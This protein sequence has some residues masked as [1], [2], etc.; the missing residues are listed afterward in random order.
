M[1]KIAFILLTVIIAS[2]TQSTDNTTV[3]EIEDL[4]V[5]EPF[6]R[7]PTYNLKWLKWQSEGTSF[8]EI[9]EKCPFCV[10][11]L[12]IPKD[13]ILKVSSE[14]DPKR[15]ALLIKVLDVFD[16]L[17]AYFPPE[18]QDKVRT[19]CSNPSNISKEQIEFLKRL[20]DEAIT[21]NDKLIALKNIS[22]FSLRETKAV[23]DY[24]KSKQI[25]MSYF[26]NFDSV[27]TQAKVARLNNSLED[28]IRTAG[29]LQGEVNLQKREISKT[30][31]QHSKD[32]NNFLFTAGYQY[33]VSINPVGNDSYQLVLKYSGENESI[34]NV[35]EHLSFGERNAFAL[36][37]FMYQT[38]REDVDLIILDDPISSFDNNKK[39][40][41]MNMLFRGSNSF[42]GK[43]VL[44]LTH[45]FEP[46]IDMVGALKH[47]FPP[48]PCAHLIANISGILEE[49]CINGQQIRSC[50]SVCKE[51]MLE[52]DDPI[53]KLIYYRRLLEI[54]DNKELEWDLVSNIFHKNRDIPQKR[55]FDGSFRDMT[56]EEIASAS[57][58]IREFI[59]NFD[60]SSVYSTTRDLRHLTQLYFST[61]SGYE[62]IMI[63]RIII[64]GELKQG[65]PLKKYID[66]TF[67]VQ[68]DYLFQL[69]PR[70]YKLVPQYIMDFCDHEVQKIQ[71]SIEC[72]DA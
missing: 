66:E 31:E 6:I 41:I 13:T 69:N 15:F 52:S 63:Y 51:N 39:F 23:I 33:E 20:K 35:K 2:C 58:A 67:H 18:T 62:K 21:L 29:M 11:N 71:A 19:I 24:L 32:I 14:Y 48:A 53:H 38:L 46:V 45:D 42:H 56:Q 37:L 36:V 9:D 8:L 55:E 30:I 60:Y 27:Q 1:K 47:I 3:R 70:H 12:S 44:M 65:S 40:A 16:S 68:N 17:K 57:D 26:P 34:T 64:D 72:N 61:T 43:T 59:V 28:V 5:Y 25:E 54:N 50:V 22:F 7:N 4:T 49:K 10:S